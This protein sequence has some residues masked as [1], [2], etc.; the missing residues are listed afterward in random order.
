M[1]EKLNDY[2]WQEAFGYAGEGG[3]CAPYQLD[4]GLDIR[5]ALPTKQYNLAP[6]TR[7]DVTEICAMREGE[8]DG[9]EWIIYGKL[10]DGRWFY[11]EAGCDYTGW[12]CHASG[13]ATIADSKEEIERYGLT[14]YAREVFQIKLSDISIVFY[15]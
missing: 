15:H 9:D 3:T 1:L 2:N 4:N 12:D 10:K 14:A 5:G 11:L 8:H 13:S 7:E 6:F